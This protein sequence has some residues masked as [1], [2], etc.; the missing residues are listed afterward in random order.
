MVSNRRTYKERERER[1]TSNSPRTC[2]TNPKS[3]NLSASS[4]ITC[5]TLHAHTH[6]RATSQWMN[7]TIHSI[8]HP[9]SAARTP[10]GQSRCSQPG[11]RV[12]MESITGC[13]SRRHTCQQPR[14]QRGGTPRRT[15]LL[16]CIRGIRLRQEA[17]AVMETVAQT[18][19][20]VIGLQRELAR[21]AQDQ[22]SKVA[23][24]VG[25]ERLERRK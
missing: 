18:H 13:L 15:K 9:R 10:R 6:T 24:L 14:Q 21:R 23:C 11:A 12:A 3:N 5:D 19:D 7:Y 4:S 22:R 2:S 8:A 16:G 17:H 25:V 20:D 1:Y